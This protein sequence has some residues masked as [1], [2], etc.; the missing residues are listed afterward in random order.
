MVERWEVGGEGWEETVGKDMQ[1]GIYIY[2]IKTK[3]KASTV[4]RLVKL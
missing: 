2:Q 3:R 1:A 4:G